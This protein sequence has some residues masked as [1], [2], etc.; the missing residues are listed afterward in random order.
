M[1][2]TH[3]VTLTFHAGTPPRVIT[4][5]ATELDT[6]RGH[7]NA[8]EFRHGC[9]L[10]IRADN[11]DYAIAAVF[12]DR[13]EFLQYM[14]FP[15]HQ[16]IIRELVTPHLKSRSAVQFSTGPHRIGENAVAADNVGSHIGI[17]R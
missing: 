13:R 15:L 11:A 8:T 10:G 17:R 7:I 9:D 16:Q 2:I 5:L 3:V 6:L 12:A 14:R 1:P 4:E